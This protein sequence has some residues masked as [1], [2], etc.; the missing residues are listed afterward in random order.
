MAV[1]D[2]DKLPIEDAQHMPR[3]ST[4]GGDTV[5]EH[6]LKDRIALDEHLNRKTNAGRS[7]GGILRQQFRHPRPGL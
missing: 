4:I 1:D 2:A 7:G 3:R 6:S 5:E